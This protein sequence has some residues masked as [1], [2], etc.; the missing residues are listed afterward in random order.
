LA[1]SP[2]FPFWLSYTTNKIIPPLVYLAG[3][4]TSTKLQDISSQPRKRDRCDRWMV[5][6]ADILSGC[7]RH[8]TAEWLARQITVA[9][10]GLAQRDVPAHDDAVAGLFANVIIGRSPFAFD[11]NL[12]LRSSRE[13]P[14]MTDEAKKA[15]AIR[16]AAEY[17]QPTIT[18]FCR[19][20]RERCG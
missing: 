1:S 5:P 15:E 9:D 20:R 6:D 16:R 11:C 4:A 3:D 14:A 12:S 7:L 13:S 17:P 10:F 2:Q 19:N 8:P 18:R